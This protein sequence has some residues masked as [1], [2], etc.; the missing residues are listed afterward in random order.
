[1]LRV[2]YVQ[3][4]QHRNMECGTEESCTR[5]KMRIRE[6]PTMKMMKMRSR[7]RNVRER[8]RLTKQ[9]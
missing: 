6:S 7:R 1:M 4:A 9:T 8:A 3:M 2:W 5:W